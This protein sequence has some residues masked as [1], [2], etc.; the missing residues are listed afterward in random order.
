M[1][2]LT[3]LTSA[4][5]VPVGATTLAIAIYGACEAAEKAARPGALKDIGRKIKDTSWERTVRPTAII[6]RTFDWTFGER[7][8][9]WRCVA[10]SLIATLASCLAL[11]IGYHLTLGIDFSF[12]FAAYKPNGPAEYEGGISVL[13]LAALGLL[14]FAILPD[15]LALGKTRILLSAIAP[16]P[17]TLSTLLLIFADIGLSIAISSCFVFLVF[18]VTRWTYAHDWLWAYVPLVEILHWGYLYSG[19]DY[20]AFSHVPD[21][22]TVKY[23]FKAVLSPFNGAYS[24]TAGFIFFSSTLLTSIWTTLMLLSVSVLKLV[25]PLHRFTAW[26]FNIEK[27]PVRTIGI[28]AGALAIAGSLIWSVLW[29]LV[30]FL[31]AAWPF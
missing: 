13:A 21:S 7:H 12:W 25:T 24:S 17:R 2:W 10:T 27:H 18:K 9:S 22:D 3:E 30:H 11:A 20:L 31:V 16:R 28:M 8:F 14:L 15:Y 6:E 1:S 19:D 23:I 5:G 29:S 4:I 26:Y